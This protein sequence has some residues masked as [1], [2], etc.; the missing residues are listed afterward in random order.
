MHYVL[1][2]KFEEIKERKETKYLKSPDYSHDII[3]LEYEYGTFYNDLS[4]LNF[5]QY[6]P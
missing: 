1:T 4:L 5:L 2:L 3:S 6:V